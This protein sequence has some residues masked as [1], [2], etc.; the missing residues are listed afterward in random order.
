MLRSLLE[1]KSQTPSKITSRDNVQ[2]FYSQLISLRTFLEKNK[3]YRKIFGVFY[4]ILMGKVPPGK[5]TKKSPGFFQ[6]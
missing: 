3:K 6:E 2:R 4:L 5:V 1:K